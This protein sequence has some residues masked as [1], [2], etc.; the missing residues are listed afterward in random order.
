MYFFHQAQSSEA[1]YSYTGEAWIGCRWWVGGWV[2]AAIPD[3]GQFR[4]Q[5]R[6]RPE[7]EKGSL[8][9]EGNP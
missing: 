1:G 6:K 9:T 5:E 7:A 3:M 8:V 2:V 4:L